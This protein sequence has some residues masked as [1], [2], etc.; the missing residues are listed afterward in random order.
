MKTIKNLPVDLESFAFIEREC[1]EAK[2]VKNKC[3]R[4][5]LYYSLH[6]YF[7]DKFNYSV[8]N[9]LLIDKNKIFGFPVNENFSWLMVQFYKIPTLFRKMGLSLFISDREINNFFD[10][11]VAMITPNKKSA[12]E[13]ILDV[14]KAIDAGCAIGIDI[15]LSFFGLLDHIMFVYGY[16]EDNMYIFDTH[17]VPDLEYEKV[18]TD[19]RYIMK[20]PKNIIKK[21]WGRLGRVWIVKK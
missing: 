10:F 16:D 4:D 9:P 3:G 13:A 12:A 21:R 6:Y 2:K 7:P 20:L 19:N 17:K 15:S 18:T 11:L 14:E 5:F 1:V 8:N